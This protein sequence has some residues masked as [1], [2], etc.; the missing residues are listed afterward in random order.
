MDR[1]IAALAKAKVDNVPFAILKG[2]LPTDEITLDHFYRYKDHLGTESKRDEIREED[3]G[4]FPRLNDYC[5]RLGNF[6]GQPNFY[7]TYMVTEIT[8][9]I[10]ADMHNDT[11]DGISWNCVGS[12]E[13]TFIDPDTEERITVLTEPGDAVFTRARTYHETKP[14]GPRAS[15]I[16]MPGRNPYDVPH[17]V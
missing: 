15:L 9:G 10:H 13:W 1:F 4:K 16:W 17:K 14:L 8:N 5:G 6:Y 7:L 3:I 11:C 2:V 12:T